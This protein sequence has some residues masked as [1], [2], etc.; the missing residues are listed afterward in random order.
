MWNTPNLVSVND[1]GLLSFANFQVVNVNGLAGDD[2]V[3]VVP[4]VLLGVTTIN[5]DGG[6]PTASDTVVINGT[7]L[8]D[9]VT[10]NN[11]TLDGASVLGLGP[12]INVTTAEHLVYNG[13][14]GDDSLTVTSGVGPDAVRFVPGDSTPDSGTV[15]VSQLSATRLPITFAGLGILGQLIIADQSGT[16]RDTLEVPGTAA[17]DV[18]N[19]TSTGTIQLFDPAS[20]VAS[21]RSV[22]VT[23]PGIVNTILSGTGGSDVFTIAANHPFSP[24]FGIPAIRA[25]W[26]RWK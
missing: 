25:E 5:V 26:R 15:V 18:F 10:I 14:G 11:L 8:T 3:N 2:K 12:A 19:V 16:R 9:N 7:N 4:G 20:G 13:F 24:A 22:L 23:T 6:S 1:R 17:D 21:F